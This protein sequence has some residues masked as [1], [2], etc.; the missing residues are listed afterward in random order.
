M[1]LRLLCCTGTL[2]AALIA[3]APATASAP[4]H[5]CEN[6]VYRPA[7][8]SGAFQIVATAISCRRARALA[9]AVGRGSTPRGWHCD[10]RRHAGALVEPHAHYRCRRGRARVKF[11]IGG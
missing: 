9:R 4:T 6:V 10:T 3:A 7:S 11:I 8:E 5:R 1:R 2:V